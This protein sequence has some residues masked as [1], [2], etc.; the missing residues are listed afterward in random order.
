MKVNLCK[1]GK[2]YY[3][4]VHRLVAETFIPNPKNLRCVNHKDGNKKNN[5]VSNLEWATNSENTKHMH[6][7]LFKRPGTYI[8]KCK[9]LYKGELIGEFDAIIDA[10]KYA[11]ERG[12]SYTSLQKYYKSNGYEII[13]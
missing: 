6:N 5:H 12:A 4:K 1:N 2:V 10:C 8:K 11:S 3:K 9:L 13:K 7:V